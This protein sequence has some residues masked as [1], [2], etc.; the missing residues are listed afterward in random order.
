MTI[1]PSTSN[2]ETEKHPSEAALQKQLVPQGA[3]ALITSTSVPQTLNPNP[4]SH[5]VALR[6]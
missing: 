4:H 1:D 6:V 2:L 5:P 3:E